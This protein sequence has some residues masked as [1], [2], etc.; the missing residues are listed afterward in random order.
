MKSRFS[1]IIALFAVLA[2]AA[3]A[4][5]QNISGSG[6]QALSARLPESDA[7]AVMDVNRLVNTALPQILA[8]NQALL[9][10]FQGTI[11]TVKDRT[12][13]DLRRFSTAAIGLK[14][15]KRGE[16]DFDFSGVVI[17][18]GDLNMPALLAAAKLAANG[19]YR[20]VKANGSTIIIFPMKDLADT[21]G[22]SKGRSAKTASKAHSALGGPAGEIAVTILDQTTLALG[23]LAQVKQ[24]VTG[25]SHVSPDLVS[26]LPKE[27]VPV[28]SFAAKT[29]D[30]MST[31]MPLDNDELGKNID[32]IKYLFG[33]MNVT[34]AGTQL[35]ATARTMTAENA[36]SL[37]ETLE[38]LQM[39]GKALLGGSKG[40]DKE[41]YARL[42]NNVVFSTTGND[43]N[44]DL[45]IEQA[46]VNFLV[47][48]LGKTH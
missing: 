31:F 24:V 15:I 25:S 22:R 30:G 44:L 2:F 18:N 23:S 40:A 43:V 5:G 35:T 9:S 21:A 33:S 26:L 32:S 17:A 1:T 36:Q 6:Y 37:K 10:D 20:E 8:G 19:K 13:I 27:A 11:D 38:G 4:F 28:F 46:D 39:I 14:A 41:V 29:P 7:A 48:L 42:V 34:P 3:A 16:K 47:G 12:G 45:A